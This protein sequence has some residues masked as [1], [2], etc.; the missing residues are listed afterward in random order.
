MLHVKI[1]K[2]NQPVAGTQFSIRPPIGP[3]YEVIYL[4]LKGGLT[5]AMLQ[6]VRV[7]VR[8]KPIQSFKSGEQ[9]QSL[10][11][12]YKRPNSDQSDVIALWFY[13]PELEEFAERKNFALG[14]ADVDTLAIVADVAA[15]APATADIE[16]KARTTAARPLGMVTKIKQYPQTFAQ[17]G[18]QD[19]ADIPTRDAAIAGIHMQTGDITALRLELDSLKIVEG[20]VA[21]LNDAYAEK[22]AAQPDFA[23]V[24]YLGRGSQF[25]ALLTESVQDFRLTLDLSQAATFPLIVEYFDTFAGL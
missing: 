9:I 2:K 15:S 7:E 23:H 16:I 18:E 8:G 4:Y 25:D 24:S 12:Y 22:Y 5:A 14:T 20:T 10:N 11:K 1:P 3:T 19:I 17:G 13:R 21:Q 6:N